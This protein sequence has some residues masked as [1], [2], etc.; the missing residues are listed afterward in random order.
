MTIAI[1]PHGA[2]IQPA[3]LNAENQ[4]LFFEDPQRLPSVPGSLTVIHEFLKRK[5]QLI[6][7]TKSCDS[8]ARKQGQWL[9]SHGLDLS[10]AD[11]PSIEHYSTLRDLGEALR[12]RGVDLVVVSEVVKRAELHN[13]PLVVLG[14]AHIESTEKAWV[15]SHDWT[16]I[17]RLVCTPIPASV[18]KRLA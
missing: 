5:H 13:L 2:L 7:L 8:A 11:D 16:Y 4:R 14:A 18:T 17:Y 12:Q 1:I 10:R 9:R 3:K 15:S 6:Y